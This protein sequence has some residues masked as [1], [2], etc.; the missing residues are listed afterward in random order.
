MFQKSKA[1]AN[2]QH[3]IIRNRV[4]MY[5]CIMYMKIMDKC[6]KFSQLTIFDT[7]ECN[8]V[9]T[10]RRHQIRIVGVEFV[11]TDEKNLNKIESLVLKLLANIFVMLL[12]KKKTRG[13]RQCKNR[14][15]KKSIKSKIIEHI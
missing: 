7:Q 3:I 8:Y 2:T 1:I 15:N 13:E 9:F 6:L 14:Q 11:T 5:A 4:R 10:E 12:L